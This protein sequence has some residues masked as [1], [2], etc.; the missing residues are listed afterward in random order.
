MRLNNTMDDTWERH[1]A[2]LDD[3]AMGQHMRARAVTLNVDGRAFLDVAP[4]QAF[5]DKMTTA[6]RLGAQSESVRAAIEW[7]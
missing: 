2:P 1:E 4:A 5:S 3:R 6:L 7:L